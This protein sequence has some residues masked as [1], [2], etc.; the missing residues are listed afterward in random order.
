MKEVIEKE[1][2]N[3]ISDEDKSQVILNNN[4]KSNSS[5]SIDESIDISTT[6][7][8]NSN[9]SSNLHTS[10]ELLPL[11]K[12]CFMHLNPVTN[13]NDLI[14]PCGCKGSIKYVHN[15]C[16]KLWRFKG[17]Q[18]K[19][20][21]KCEQCCLPYNV[22][23]DRLPTK[24]LIR[25]SCIFC[26]S[27]VL[28]VSNC[29]FNS[30]AE[31]FMYLVDDHFIEDE[32]VWKEFFDNRWSDCRFGVG[33]NRR[34]VYS[35]SSDS[36]KWYT[37]ID[38]FFDKIVK[39]LYKDAILD[40]NT[41]NSNG[42]LRSQ[43]KVDR[44]R[45][46]LNNLNHFYCNK[47]I[48]DQICSKF[49]K[50]MYENEYYNSNNTCKDHSN[51][52]VYT[53]EYTTEYTDTCLNSKNNDKEINKEHYYQRNTSTNYNTSKDIHI[54][55]NS[56][57]YT[58]NNNTITN[59]NGNNNTNT[60][61]Y[62]NTN[63]DDDK[64]YSKMTE[65]T[66]KNED[67][68]MNHTHSKTEDIMLSE[69]NN[70]KN[71]TVTKTVLKESLTRDINKNYGN[72][73][74][75]EVKKTNENNKTF[76]SINTSENEKNNSKITDL[77]TNIS[78][79]HSAENSNTTNTNNTTSNNKKPLTNTIFNDLSSIYI[80]KRT[81]KVNIN[82][83]IELYHVSLYTSTII[84]ILLYSMTMC[85]RPLLCFNFLFTVWR[86]YYWNFLFDRVLIYF[87]GFFYLRSFYNS[88]YEYMDSLYVYLLNSI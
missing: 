1:Q 49:A 47:N 51:N 77:N 36:A 27:M 20:I 79:D 37:F 50:K 41:S 44:F 71:T 45:N 33:C 32:M 67:N 76:F 14:T 31:A 23:T 15:T 60:V 29:V 57:N 22:D 52:S 28:L 40:S 83:I 65:K 82:S 78:S 13:K 75:K 30:I 5:I 19:E 87:F 8:T 4:N 66:N 7:S 18:L 39:F 80:P 59:S 63:I 12:I 25:L 88:L 68:L 6:S 70:S 62:S 34:F 16:L 43:C 73:E 54:D 55:L 86:I 81:K 24:I 84:V 61:T 3:K 56:G 2:K 53:K 17:K 42:S 10:E 21:K 11:C 9:N 69:K 38:A 26:I 35:D 64:S 72:N 46:A 74:K 48:S 85:Y 58:D